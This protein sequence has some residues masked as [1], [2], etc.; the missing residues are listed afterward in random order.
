MPNEAK[1]PGKSNQSGRHEDGRPH[2]AGRQ[3]PNPRKR[4]AQPGNTNAVTHGLYARHLPLNTLQAL[5]EAHYLSPTDLQKEI[6]LSRARLD[7]L[8]EE[9]GLTARDVEL[10]LELVAR[11]VA[12]HYRISPQARGDLADNL[13]AIL[14]SLGDQLLPP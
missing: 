13:S 3:P 12:R 1:P 2:P 10:A 5:H 7:A 9:Q 6:A 14:N 11:L 8:I 4:G